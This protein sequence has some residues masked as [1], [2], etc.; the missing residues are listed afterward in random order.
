MLHG[1]GANMLK[2]GSKRR[3]TKQ[4][5]KDDDQVKLDRENEIRTKFAQLDQLQQ[6]MEQ[7]QQQASENRAAAVLMSDLVNAGVVKQKAENSFVVQG[8]D[9]ELNFDYVDR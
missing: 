6:Q 5:V 9:G 7:M 3:R 1:I 4:E 2:V 8:P